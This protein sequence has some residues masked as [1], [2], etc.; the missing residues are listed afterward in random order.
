[1]SYKK[2]YSAQCI[3]KKGRNSRHRENYSEKNNNCMDLEHRL[4][5]LGYLYLNIGC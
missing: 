5:Q 1:M 2:E 3:S 4:N